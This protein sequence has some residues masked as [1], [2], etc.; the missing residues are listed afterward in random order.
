MPSENAFFLDTP[1]T[2]TYAL[3]DFTTGGREFHS[4]MNREKAISAVIFDC[5]GVMFDS[6]QANIDFYNHLLGRFGLPP[7]RD[8]QV[9]FVHMHTVQESVRYLFR[10]TS[11]E[12]QAQAYRLNMDYT[13]F[14]Q[15]MI[16]EPGLKDL[17][18]ALKRRCGLAVATN[19]STTIGEVLRTFGLEDYFDIVVSSLDVERPKPNPEALHKILRFFRIEPGRAVYV[20]DSIVDMETATAARVP[21]IS[22]K[23]RALRADYHVDSLQ[24]IGDWVL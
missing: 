9:A 12:G 1:H 7:M 15:A 2:G 8:E 16:M 21:F 17:L 18:E 3:I 6:R 14:I 22:Y 10:D 4:F 19:R 13:P 23:N 24:E 11:H 5:D 20:G